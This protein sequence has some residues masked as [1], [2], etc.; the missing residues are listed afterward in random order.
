M[1]HANKQKSNYKHVSQ[2]S[3]TNIWMLK[4]KEKTWKNLNQKNVAWHY[5][6]SNHGLFVDLGVATFF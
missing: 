6:Y 2:N 1:N 3:A 5:R 4:I